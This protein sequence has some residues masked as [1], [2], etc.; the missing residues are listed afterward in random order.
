MTSYDWFTRGFWDGQECG[1]I[2]VFP[3][4]EAERAW[5]KGYKLGKG[6]S[7]SNENKE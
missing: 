7:A 3:S 5:S 4:A 6:N 2:P 1:C